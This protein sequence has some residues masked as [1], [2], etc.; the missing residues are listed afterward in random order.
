[1]L[2]VVEVMFSL[3]FVHSQELGDLKMDPLYYKKVLWF[4]FFQNQTLETPV[5]EILKKA[6]QKMESLKTSKP[7]S[8]QTL[9]ASPYDPLQNQT[10]LISETPQAHLTKDNRIAIPFTVFFEHDPIEVI[11]YHII[12]LTENAAL[13]GELLNLDSTPHLQAVPDYEALSKL[14]T[15]IH[16][17]DFISTSQMT[18]ISISFRILTDEAG[19]IVP[20]GRETR[21][22]YLYEKDITQYPIETIPLHRL[23][24]QLELQA[25]G[26]LIQDIQLDELN[27]ERVQSIGEML[28]SVFIFMV[29][30]K[31]FTLMEQGIL[32]FSSRALLWIGGIFIIDASV[33]EGFEKLHIDLNKHNQKMRSEYESILVFLTDNLE[34]AKRGQFHV[35]QF[36]KEFCFKLGLTQPLAEEVHLF[37]TPQDWAAFVMQKEER[38]NDY[39][40]KIK[41]YLERQSKIIEETLTRLDQATQRIDPETGEIL[42]DLPPMERTREENT[43]ALTWLSGACLTVGEATY[44]VLHRIKTVLKTRRFFAGIS[45]STLALYWM[46]DIHVREILT[47]TDLQKQTLEE[48]FQ[49]LKARIPKLIETYTL[50]S[51]TY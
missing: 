40:L 21:L 25:V 18:H 50:L 42:W 27:N 8:F 2:V 48:D 9:F 10:I 14:N 35:D 47:L 51:K 12:A 23:L 33:Q 19:L 30:D 16:V 36:K 49:K 4:H 45:V 46:W 15:P 41:T 44:K 22:T 24:N 29:I 32:R 20:I 13:A 37:D 1:M 39:F 6:A 3:P 38:L 28:V 17:G 43:T 26:S 5:L 34:K 7:Y 11:C 31:R